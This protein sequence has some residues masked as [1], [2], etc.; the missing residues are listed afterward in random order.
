ME[1]LARLYPID[2]REA[3]DFSQ[4][5]VSRVASFQQVIITQPP[6]AHGSTFVGAIA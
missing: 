2:G 5:F 1:H 3:N 6:E 4:S